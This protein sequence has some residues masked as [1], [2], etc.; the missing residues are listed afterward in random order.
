MNYGTIYKEERKWSILAQVKKP[1]IHGLVQSIMN[2]QNLTETQRLEYVSL[3]EQFSDDFKE[4]MYK[5]SIELNDLYP[6]GMDIWQKF[7]SHPS[8]RKYVDAYKNEQIRKNIDVAL[9]SGDKDA[10]QIKKEMERESGKSTFENFV[11]FR[12]PEKEKDY[13]FTSTPL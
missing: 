5:T 1:T 11:V 13:E 4:N 6:F 8:V 9:R 10:I 2:D 7:L 3:A 12:L